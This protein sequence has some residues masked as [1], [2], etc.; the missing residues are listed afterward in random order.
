MTGYRLQICL[1]LLVSALAMNLLYN[2][3]ASS[4]SFVLASS[5]H[6]GGG[7]GVWLGGRPAGGVVTHSASL[8]SATPSWSLNA[9]A[10][11][12]HCVHIIMY[13]GKHDI[14]VSEVYNIVHDSFRTRNSSLEGATEVK[15]VPLRSS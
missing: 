5:L 12:I 15:I 2:F 8:I 1:T 6:G 7:G 13:R 10:C 11:F 14:R 4:S 3:A 9:T